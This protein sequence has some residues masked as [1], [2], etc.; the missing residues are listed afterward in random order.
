MA[1]Q[2]RDVSPD[3]VTVVVGERLPDS[4]PPLSAHLATTAVAV[5]AIA[6]ERFDRRCGYLVEELADD[7]PSGPATG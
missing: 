4:A 1:A 6:G 3:I 7:D 2:L 5:A